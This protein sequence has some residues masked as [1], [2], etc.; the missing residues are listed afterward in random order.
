MVAEAVKEWD[1]CGLARGRPTSLAT[2]ETGGR[3]VRSCLVVEEGKTIE[4]RFLQFAVG[5]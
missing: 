2:V 4:V 3:W 5:V 1:A